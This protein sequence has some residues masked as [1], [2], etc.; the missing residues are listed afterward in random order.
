[1]GIP[2]ICNTGIGDTDEM[3]RSSQS[4]VICKSFDEKEYDRCTEEILSLEKTLNKEFTRSK[5]IELFSLEN[6]VNCYHAIYQEL[7]TKNDGRVH[8]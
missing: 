3:I 8:S 1:M 5:A 6:G 7:I 2:V 4:G